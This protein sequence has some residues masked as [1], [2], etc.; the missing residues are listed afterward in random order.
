MKPINVTFLFLTLLTISITASAKQDAALCKNIAF[1]AWN[2]ANDRD[3]G[4]SY[5]A[6]LGKLKGAAEDTEKWAKYYES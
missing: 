4:T 5:H 1:S 2:I 6:E 3:Q